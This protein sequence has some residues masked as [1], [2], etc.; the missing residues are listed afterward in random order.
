MYSWLGKYTIGRISRKQELLHFADIG[1]QDQVRA[2]F[3][4][5]LNSELSSKLWEC[6]TFQE[7]IEGKAAADE[8]YFY[9]YCRSLLY[10]GPQL[11]HLKSTMQ[12]IHH[13]PLQK[14]KKVV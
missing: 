10:E 1:D 5:N 11:D 13:V 12:L 8:I 2:R 7:F 14:A 9:L 3:W 6:I 4:Y